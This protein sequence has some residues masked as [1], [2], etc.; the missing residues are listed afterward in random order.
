MR[1]QPLPI[2][3]LI[4]IMCAYRLGLPVVGYAEPV[5]LM[6]HLGC[7]AATNLQMPY[8]IRVWA[9]RDIVLSVLVVSARGSIIK[10]LL[11]A[12]VAVDATDVLSAQI[13]GAA[14]LFNAANTWSLTLTAVA[15]LVPEIAALA[16][17]YRRQLPA[18]R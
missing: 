4:G 11:W 1:G 3:I 5:W 2:A 9:I 17:I 16:L 18:Q 6:E 8:I 13:S 12:C 14:S 7:P 10:A 15:A